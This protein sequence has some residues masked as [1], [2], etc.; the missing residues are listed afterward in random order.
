MHLLFDVSIRSSGIFGN[1][2]YN[3]A[4]RKRL[5]TFPNP[6]QEAA[7]GNSPQALDQQDGSAIPI[8][9]VDLLHRRLSDARIDYIVLGPAGSSHFPLGGEAYAHLAAVVLDDRN[10]G[11]IW[12]QANMVILK[13][14]S[15]HVRGQ[16]MLSHT[17][18]A[19][20]APVVGIGKK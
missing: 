17:V 14:G 18:L 2:H 15:V 10:Y 7:W 13:R 6:F 12:A 1:G 11:V 9:P 20:D 5:Y 19:V 3:L 8:L 4:H 16:E